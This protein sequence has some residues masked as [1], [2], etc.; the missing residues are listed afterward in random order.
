MDVETQGHILTVF[1]DHQV[2]NPYICHGESRLFA[3]E[4]RKPGRITAFEDWV[5]TPTPPVWDDD[6]DLWK[7]KRATVWTQ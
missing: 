2:E 7:D 3:W 6:A 5:P 1:S 4:D